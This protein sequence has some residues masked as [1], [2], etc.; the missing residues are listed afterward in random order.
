MLTRKARE[1][2]TQVASGVGIAELPAFWLQVAVACQV[3]AL[4]TLSPV[5]TWL[6]HALIHV[7]LTALTLITCRG[8]TILPRMPHAPAAAQAD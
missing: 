1:A 3:R 6:P 5:L 2:Q 4:E 8:D 7:Q